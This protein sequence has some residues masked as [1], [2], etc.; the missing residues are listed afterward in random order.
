MVKRTSLSY[1]GGE[2]FYNIWL[3][4]PTQ[5]RPLDQDLAPIRAHP[6]V[7]AMNIFF[8][9][10]TPVPGKGQ[11]VCHLPSIFSLV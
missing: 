1:Q 7:H 5:S 10:V 11:S 2:K 6:G 3:R 9:S 8:F 4:N